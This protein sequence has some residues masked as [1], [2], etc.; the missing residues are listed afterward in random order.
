MTV[1]I[2]ATGDEIVDGDT[3]NSNSCQI[4]HTLHSEG[5]TPGLHV[6]CGD[7]E[8]D[9]RLCLEFL[10]RDHDIIVITGGLGPTS[11]DRT[12]FALARFLGISLVSFPEA[13]AH[14][15]TR[16]QRYRKLSMSPGNQQQ[17][18]FPPD[19]LLLPNPNGTA[20]GCYYVRQDKRYILLPGPPR[21]C[22]PML[23]QYVL[24]LLE[25]ASHTDR[26]VLKWRVFGMAESEIAQQLDDALAG[27]DCETGYRLE[28]PYV[29]CKVRCHHHLVDVVQQIVEPLVAP[30]IIAGPEKKASDLLADRIAELG[31][32]LSVQDN[33]TGGH[34][35]CLLQKPANY[36]LLRFTDQPV[37]ER[38]HFE[39]NGLV[40]Y[41][42]QNTEQ[43]T[44]AITI[45]YRYGHKTGEESHEL[46]Y[47]SALVIH[48]AAEW[49]CF[50]L[51]HLI[52]QL[53]EG[54]A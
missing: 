5:L 14:I 53:H 37:P 7:K 21:E 18:L 13:L 3:L 1:G 23:H 54:V 45:N 29:E 2:L 17:A 34:L 52:D 44:T 49:L 47:R 35:Q 28:T 27:V 6:T 4:A 15:Q 19:A 11:D 51:L 22:L 26:R 40:E 43:T 16:L 39:L 10:A 25:T 38:L 48:L 9:I 30:H 20:M 31:L 46:P 41:W 50:R 24:P 8:D 36:H 32:T 12:R 42:T 33:V